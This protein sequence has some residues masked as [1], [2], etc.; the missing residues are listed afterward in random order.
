MRR[1]FGSHMARPVRR[2]ERGRATSSVK[3]G[4]KWALMQD[5][6]ST[7]LQRSSD[8]GVLVHFDLFGARN[9]LTVGCSV[10]RRRFGTSIVGIRLVQVKPI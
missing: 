10:S 8:C 5:G 7:V 2:C 6:V 3:S 1:S 9:S 4:R